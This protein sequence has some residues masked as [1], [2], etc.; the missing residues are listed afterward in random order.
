ML[1]RNWRVDYE[2]PEPYEEELEQEPN[3]HE[4]EKTSEYYFPGKQLPLDHIKPMFV[5]CVLIAKIACYVLENV[6]SCVD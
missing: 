5:K 4:P 6:M 1:F 3:D 2:A